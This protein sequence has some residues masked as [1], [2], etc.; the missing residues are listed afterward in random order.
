MAAG[1]QRP[2]VLC[3]SAYEAA[4]HRQWRELLERSLP[5]YDWHSL[6][7]PP[8]HFRWRIRGN[9]LSWLNEPLLEQSWD[10]VIAT[11]MVDLATLRGIQPSLARVPAIAYFHENQFAY[12]DRRSRE[13]SNEP[14]VVNLYT[15]LSADLVLFNS[16][17]NR[18]SLLVGVTQ[19]MR[20]LP[21]RKP[22]GLTSRIEAKSRVL[23]VPVDD[24][25]FLDR[26]RQWST[27]PHLVWN[28]R[29]EYDKG[30]ERLLLILRALRR[31]EVAFR[32]SLVG[33]QFRV[34]PEEFAIIQEEFSTEL[35]HC[36]FLPTEQAYRGLLAEADVVISTALHDFQG[37][38]VLE[39][40]AAG[41]VPVVPDRLAYPEYVP[42]EYR[43]EASEQDPDQEAEAAAALIQQMIASP[44][45]A[46]DRF[47]PDAHRL[48]RLLPV[49][50][51]V[52]ST[53]L[54]SGAAPE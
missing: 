47:Q 7:L 40:M 54:G 42:A 14:A 51:E 20:R 18:R 23:P 39:A 11:S 36:G 5:G 22:C 25:C 50:E 16:D 49:Y 31:R 13:Q 15:T 21:D 12:P 1:D 48:S 24:E 6:T 10:L 53:M 3:L 41:A 27:V 37:L 33:Q 44:R 30:P 4:S 17:W 38:A 9:P 19:L 34:A 35:L 32:L 46:I 52:F 28:H 26:D 8:R 2:R 29:W 43:Y 45:P